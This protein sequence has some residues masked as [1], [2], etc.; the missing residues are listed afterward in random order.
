[1]AVKLR[2]MRMG[3]RHK[4]F[5][6]LNAIDTRTPRDGKIIEKLGHYDPIE[7]DPAKQLVLKKDR[8][9]Y[10]LGIGAVPSETVAELIAK[11]GIESEHYK[12]VK[13][14]RKRAKLA[15]RKKGVPFDNTQRVVA[16]KA[17]EKAVA[18]KAAAEK[19]AEAVV[20]KPAEKP[21]EK[22]EKQADKK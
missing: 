12:Q 17:A 7:K 16:K 10:W 22:T 1:M 6:R 13:A 5:F 20:E 11:I 14:R 15:A 18:E 3:R 2:L 9:E 21:A 19:P 8:I 4:P